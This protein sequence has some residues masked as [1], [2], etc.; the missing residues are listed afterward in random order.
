M[1]TLPIWISKH[2]LVIGE[3]TLNAMELPAKN[4]IFGIGLSRT[5]TTSL[6]EAL[7]IL[8]YKS[9]HFPSDK[10]TIVE[11]F[12]FL[13][14]GAEYIDLTTLKEYDAITDTPVCCFYK[15]LDRSYPDSK[16]IL[17]I[18]DKESWLRSCKTF[19]EEVID[20]NYRQGPVHYRFNRY[21]RLINEKLYGTANYDPEAFSRT[22]DTYTADILEYF[23]DRPQDF[24]ILDIIGGEGWSKLA[25]FL[26]TAIPDIPFPFENPSSKNREHRFVAH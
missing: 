26:G 7:N 3:T 15:V 5:G 1:D 10:S 4:K 17:T 2:R 11:I 8:G 25:P 14:S 21:V 22:Y 13:A 24:L 19:W 16:F 9:Y 23:R 18:R 20:F 6:T 12:N